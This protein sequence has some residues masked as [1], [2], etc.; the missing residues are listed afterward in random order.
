MHIMTFLPQYILPNTEGGTLGSSTPPPPLPSKVGRTNV[1]MC[2]VVFHLFWTSFLLPHNVF[3]P[4][5]RQSP[6]NKLVILSVATV[7][8]NGSEISGPVFLYQDELSTP[9]L[10]AQDNGSLVCRSDDQTNLDWHSPSNTPLFFVENFLQL[11]SGPGVTPMESR[12]VV[13]QAD[14]ALADDTTKGLWS[15]GSN[16]QQS[17]SIAVGIY[18][19]LPGNYKHSN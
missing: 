16:G 8:W 3:P 19:R 7:F 5:K 2:I 15:C 9:F 10:P 13:N 17:S 14:L 4:R 6:A 12:L 18:A 11:R 1:H